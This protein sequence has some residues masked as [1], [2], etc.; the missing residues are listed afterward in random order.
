MVNRCLSE[1]EHEQAGSAQGLLCGDHLGKLRNQCQGGN[2]LLLKLPRRLEEHQTFHFEIPLRAKDVQEAMKNP[3]VPFL[4]SASLFDMAK[5]AIFAD[6]YEVEPLAQAALLAFYRMLSQEVVDQES[7]A[8]VCKLVNTVY[9]NTPCS[10]TNDRT[11]RTHVLRRMLIEFVEAHRD[12]FAA[13]QTFKQLLYQG[14]DLAADLFSTTI[15][16]GLRNA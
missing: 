7:V 2:V 9:D 13:S 10:F 12:K 4:E 3:F 1:H 8:K 14:N 5:L 16:R 11:E 6:I 15:Q